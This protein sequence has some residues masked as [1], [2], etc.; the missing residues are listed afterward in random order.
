MPLLWNL[1]NREPN[2]KPYVTYAPFLDSQT[3][4]QPKV[5]ATPYYST[6]NKT[7]MDKKV[8]SNMRTTECRKYLE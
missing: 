6:A 3:S 4:G 8:Q 2:T 7:E 1:Q 5:N